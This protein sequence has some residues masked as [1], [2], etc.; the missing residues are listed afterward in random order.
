MST[1]DYQVLSFQDAAPLTKI[2]VYSMD[3]YTLDIRGKEFK[4]VS[5][6]LINGVKSPEFIVLTSRRLLAEVPRSEKKARIRS[7]TVLL[8]RSGITKRSSISLRA[9]VPGARAQGFTRMTQSFLRMLFT[10]PGSD[11]Q[12]P[13]KGGG[14]GLLLGATGDAGALRAQAAQAVKN[15][16][17]HLI[18]LQ[19]GNPGL[20][21]SERLR[22]ATLVSADYSAASTAV[23]IRLRLTAMDGSTHEPVVSV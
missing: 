2:D 17:E 9:V 20:E 15:A 23:S 13:E 7:V 21:D 16:E 3:P 14:L 19:A 4:A 10:N 22:S 11:I 1:V 8:S 18:Q 5:S 6:V 12:N